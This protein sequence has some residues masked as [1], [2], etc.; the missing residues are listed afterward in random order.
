MSF[1]H[2]IKC[3]VL[4]VFDLNPMLRP[5]GLIGPVAMLGDET[6]QPELAGFAEGTEENPLRCWARIKPRLESVNH[7]LICLWVWLFRNRC[8]VI[9]HLLLFHVNL[10]FIVWIGESQL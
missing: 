10:T 5:T 1:L 8:S 7:K 4:P 6:L 3:I 2:T 9:P